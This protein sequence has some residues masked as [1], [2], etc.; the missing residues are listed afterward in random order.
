[1]WIIDLPLTKNAMLKF[2]TEQVASS[3]IKTKPRTA[4]PQVAT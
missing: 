4:V 3:K 2:H 1:M